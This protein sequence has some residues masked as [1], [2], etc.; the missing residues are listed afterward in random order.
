MVGIDAAPD[1]AVGQP[2]L[3]MFQPFQALGQ[4]VPFPTGAYDRAQV[5]AAMRHTLTVDAM[6]TQLAIL[7][8]ARGSGWWARSRPMRCWS[9]CSMR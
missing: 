1:D 3:K 4:P 6:R 8:D 9:R 7:P 2:Y 5:I